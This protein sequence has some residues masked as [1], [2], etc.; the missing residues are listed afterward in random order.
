MPSDFSKYVTVSQQV[1]EMLREFDPF[2]QSG[3]IDEAF[4]DVTDF[5]RTHGKTGEEVAE[6]IRTRVRQATYTLPD[7]TE[8]VR[9]LTCSCGVAP[10]RRLA[11]VCSDIN[12]PDGQYSIA[13][14]RDEMLHFVSSLPIRKI[15]GIGKVTERMLHEVFRVSTCADLRRARAG[16]SKLLH[17]GT[18]EF[19]MTV[20]LGLGA[21]ESH[22]QVEKAGH[23]RKGISCERTFRSISSAQD[24]EGKAWELAEALAADMQS[25]RL[26][27]KTLTLKLKPVT[28]HTFTRAVT[29]PTH[30]DDK[31]SIYNAALQLLR[32]EYPLNIRLMGIRMSN[33][34]HLVQD[35]SDH[36][37]A[38]MRLPSCQPTLHFFTNQP[39]LHFFTNQSGS[40]AGGAVSAEAVS[41]EA[42]QLLCTL[43]GVNAQDATAALKRSGGNVER[44]AD[45]LLSRLD[46][47]AQ[48]ASAL[49]FVA[50]PGLLQW[51]DTMPAPLPPHGCTEDVLHAAG[52]HR[53]EERGRGGGRDGEMEGDRFDSNVVRGL[54]TA[55]GGAASPAR[56]RGAP[57]GRGRRGGGGGGGGGSGSRSGGMITS[58]FCPLKPGGGGFEGGGEGD[59]C[60][61]GGGG[62]RG[63]GGGGCVSGN[64]SP[65]KV[66]HMVEMGF[67]RQRA[68]AALKDTGGRLELAVTRLMYSSPSDCQGR[69]G[70]G[71]GAQDARRRVADDAQGSKRHKS[72]ARA[73]YAG[74]LD[75]FLHRS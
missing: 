72:G 58:F 62:R 33:L 40:A 57:A 10:N 12:K 32:K 75:V 42:V 16:I 19:L 17:R 25:Q 24:L 20:A 26:E 47:A 73:P 45:S 56:Q 2:L 70:E 30:T 53:T 3:G 60:E 67:E 69:G 5:M 55:R 41:V 46:V 22:E 23:E 71:R 15:G 13:A 29:L 1:K 34:V 18:A 43:P 65:S 39:A 27:G 36:G 52:R 51:Q 66:E 74:P 35:G 21:T 37:S 31:E 49:P 63:G 59:G 8:G 54:L 50:P 7:V 48:D 61:R 6:E 11:K 68:L 4:L 14:R 28:Y 9:G 44:A 64:G 38:A